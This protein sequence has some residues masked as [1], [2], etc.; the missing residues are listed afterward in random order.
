MFSLRLEKTNKT[1]PR[2]LL[3]D[4]SLVIFHIQSII[5]LANKLGIM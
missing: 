1:L 2:V 5:K 4:M 3:E